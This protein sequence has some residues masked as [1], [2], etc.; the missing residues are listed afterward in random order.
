V[1]HALYVILNPVLNSFQHY[2]RI[3]NVAGAG[4]SETSSE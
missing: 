2:F 3:S 1:R 4:D